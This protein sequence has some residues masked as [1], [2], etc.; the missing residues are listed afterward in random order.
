[1]G[2][3]STVALF[4]VAL[5]GCS[6][7]PPP[8]ASPFQSIGNNFFTGA[9]DK[10]APPAEIERLAREQCAGKQ[11]CKVMGWTDA[12]LVA[13]AMPMTDRETAGIAFTYS[14]N[15]G[16]G[17]DEAAWNCAVFAQADKARCL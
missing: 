4:A 5:A 6:A 8:P 12:A 14:L 11:F 17:L 2:K 9:I 16:S 7:A 1:M 15:R 3:L 10:A 13:S